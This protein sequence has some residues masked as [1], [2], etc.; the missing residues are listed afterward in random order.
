MLTKLSAS[1][2]WEVDQEVLL[3]SYPPD[4]SLS[5]SLWTWESSAKAS[6]A[7]ALQRI[8]EIKR[9]DGVDINSPKAPGLG[10]W[11]GGGDPSQQA[12]LQ[13]Y[14]PGMQLHRACQE[15]SPLS[16]TQVQARSPNPHLT[17]HLNFSVK[18]RSRIFHGSTLHMENT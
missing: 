2:S 3:A 12:G 18:T 14:L 5:L 13:T 10:C 4:S 17:A 6:M 1:L 9:F 15:S 8:T 11:A 7:Q 16:R